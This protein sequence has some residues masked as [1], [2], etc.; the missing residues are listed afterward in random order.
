MNRIFKIISGLAIA[1]L[2]AILVAP[3]PSFDAPLSTVAEA[4]DGS[5]LGARVAADGQWRFPPPDS[6][7]DKY[8]TCLVN[9]EDRWFRWHPG[10]NPVAVFRALIGNIR[11]GEIV[12]GGSTITM[13]VARMARGN[14]DRTYTGKIIEMLSAVKLEL[15]RSKKAILKLYAAN[16]PFG[17]NTVGIEAAAWRYTGRGI[18]DMT[19]AEA[20][21]LAVLPNAPSLIYPGRNSEQLKLKRDRLLLTLAERGHIDTLVSLSPGQRCRCHR[22]RLTLLTGY[23]L[24]SRAHGGGPP[25]TLSCS[26]RCQSLLT[27]MYPPLRVTVS[28][29]PPPWW[30]RWLPATLLP[31][32]ATAPSPTAPAGTAVMLI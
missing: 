19:W 5:L 24:M 11:A 28:T 12:S 23:G 16:A 25:L 13:Q 8:V 3:M 9:Y 17:G 20:A 21:T 29:T 27:G 1:G 26:A 22:W 10:V 6:L 7:P 15:F 18:A 2:I 14:P 4:A 30:L 31:G 32:W